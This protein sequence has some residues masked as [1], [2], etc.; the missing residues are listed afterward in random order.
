MNEG[1]RKEN[2]GCISDIELLKKQQLSNLNQ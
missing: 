2:I 1:K